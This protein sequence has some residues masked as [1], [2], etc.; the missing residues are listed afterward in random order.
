MLNG[1]NI[2]NIIISLSGCLGNRI[3]FKCGVTSRSKEQRKLKF[4]RQVMEE[5]RTYL[6][7]S[8]IINEKNCDINTRPMCGIVELDSGW[9]I[10]MKERER[11]LRRSIRRSFTG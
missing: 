1:K 8:I 3:V 5:I 4:T 6:F 9:K 10:E 11:E 2:I 7:E